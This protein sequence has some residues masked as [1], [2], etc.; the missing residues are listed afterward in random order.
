MGHAMLQQILFGPVP[1]GQKV[2]YYISI[3]VIFKAFYTKLCVLTNK[4]YKTYI[5]QDFHSVAR[6][7]PQRTQTLGA[8]GSKI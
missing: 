7:M 5:E 4:R 3:T 6:V 8:W 1:P 2:K